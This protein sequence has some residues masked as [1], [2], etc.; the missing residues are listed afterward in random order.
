M[1][2]R[3]PRRG[4]AFHTT[5]S[6]YIYVPIWRALDD[7]PSISQV[8][9]R[10]DWN[11]TETG[12]DTVRSKERQHWGKTVRAG[13]ER[14]EKRHQC[15]KIQILKILN[16]TR[17]RRKYLHPRWSKVPVPSVSTN[18]INPRIKIPRSEQI[19]YQAMWHRTTTKSRKILITLAFMFKQSIAEGHKGH[20]QQHWLITTGQC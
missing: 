19:S 17:T 11:G 15:V 4:Q 2:C 3:W 1:N 13:R 7:T 16:G 20:M 9:P 5:R 6:M 12:C 14:L 18:L 10:S 8:R